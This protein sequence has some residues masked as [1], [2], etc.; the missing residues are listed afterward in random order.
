VQ[1]DLGPLPRFPL[2]SREEL[3]GFIVRQSP[4]VALRKAATVT[5]NAAWNY[6]LR[7]VGLIEDEQATRAKQ[8]GSHATASCPS[9]NV[10]VMKT[11]ARI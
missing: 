1:G 5:S 9:S 4:E 6:V 10:G 2:S 7:F 11:F 3:C 8:V